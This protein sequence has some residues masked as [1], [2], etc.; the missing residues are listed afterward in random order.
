MGLG[1]DQID[2]APDRERRGRKP[3][4]LY[5]L[6]YEQGGRAIMNEGFTVWRIPN[7]FC[8]CGLYDPYVPY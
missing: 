4:D 2:I 3:G 5:E 8:L 1:Q 7:S 6:G